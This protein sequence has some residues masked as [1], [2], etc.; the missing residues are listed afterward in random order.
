LM[1]SGSGGTTAAPESPSD[2]AAGAREGAAA[3]DGQVV[4]EDEVLV[5]EDTTKDPRFAENAWLLEK[6]VRFYAGAPLRTSGGLVLGVL[7]AIDTKPRGFSDDARRVLQQYADD[8]MAGMEAD[9]ASPAAA[10]SE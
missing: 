5:I 3:L 10:G 1:E 7:S 2:L 9:P 4:S 6:G 8:L